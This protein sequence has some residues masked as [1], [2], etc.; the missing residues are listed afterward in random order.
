MLRRLL[1]WKIQAAA[2]G[3]LD[4]EVRRKLRRATVAGAAA[5]PRPGV[6]LGREWRGVRH[7]VEVTAD[8]FVYAGATYPSLS[9]VALTIT[10]VKWNGPRFFGLRSGAAA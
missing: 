3:D 10:G 1:A 8:G 7:D 2:F 6:Q 9:K 5:A 4:P